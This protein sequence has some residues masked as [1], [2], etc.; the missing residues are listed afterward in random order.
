MTHFRQFRTSRS[1]SA[2]I[3]SGWRH[4]ESRRTHWCRRSRGRRPRCSW[5]LRC[6]EGPAEGCGHGGSTWADMDTTYSLHL[7]L[8]RRWLEEAELALAHT[9]IAWWS[10]KHWVLLCSGFIFG[11]T[12]FCQKV[13]IV[14]PF[15]KLTPTLRQMPRDVV[16]II[17][18]D[19]LLA[20][21]G[22]LVSYFKFRFGVRNGP[23]GFSPWQFCRICIKNDGA[24]VWCSFHKKEFKSSILFQEKTQSLNVIIRKM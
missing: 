20:V 8:P 14:H 7:P 6:P 9:R 10:D 5:R 18:E 24:H 17:Q 19:W 1:S 15:L 3:P 21:P 4:R 22:F 11:V 12:F 2:E 16:T 23:F 13:K